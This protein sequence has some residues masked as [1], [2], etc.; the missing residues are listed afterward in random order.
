MPNT[1]RRAV[2]ANAGNVAFR[3]VAKAT[4]TA[5]AL[6][7]GGKLHPKQGLPGGS[8]LKDATKPDEDDEAKDVAKRIF[9]PIL[10]ADEQIVTG[11]VLVP[12]VV[13]G[14]GDIYS[15]EVIRKAAHE[16]LAAFN[17]RTKLGLL[18]E[19]FNK[20]FELLESYLAPGDL[21]INNR[22]VKMGS[23]VITVKVKDGKIWKQVK[24]GKLRGF[25]VGGK[26]RVVKLNPSTFSL[27]SST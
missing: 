21:V 27:T 13:D 16:F 9:V 19:Q 14:Q 5:T 20:R 25:S 26:A 10:K 2:P 11:V 15:A 8:G 17:K 12:E 7:T 23:W 1:K 18:H 22:A 6:D 3:N 24:D 4:V